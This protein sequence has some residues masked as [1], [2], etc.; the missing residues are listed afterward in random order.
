MKFALTAENIRTHADDADKKNAYFCPVCGGAVIPRQGAMNAWHFAHQVSCVDTWNYDMSEWHRSWQERF[1]SD[2]R[3][4]VVE[5]NGECHRADILVGKYVIEFQHSQISASEFEERNSFYTSAGYKVI[6]VF[7]EVATFEC[8][9]ISNGDESVDKFVWK[10]PNRALASVVPQHSLD[11]AII[12][13]LADESDDDSFGWLAK[14]EWAI[15]KDDGFADYRHFL[16]DD[17]FS[18]N[19]FTEEGR[20][21]IFLNKRQRFESFLRNHR[22]YEPKCSR[23][24]GYP[25]AWYT[26]PKTNDWHNNRCKECPHNLISEHRKRTEYRKG[27]LFFYCCYPNRLHEPNE[28]GEYRLPTINT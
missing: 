9:N 6:W 28:Y 18:P 11:I 4:V 13:Q 26:C 22:P 3:E 20:Q 23:I 12:L 8:E 5:H 15:K 17:N 2:V 14:I 21:D 27:G 25:Q 19:L 10:W 7:D 24:K 1:P 16:I